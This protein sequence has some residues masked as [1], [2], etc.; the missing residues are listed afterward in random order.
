MKTLSCIL[1]FIIISGWSCNSSSG[2]GSVVV[3][4]KDDSLEYYPPT[5]AQLDR[6]VFR[7]Y[8]R[9]LSHYFDSTLLRRG[10]N[11]GIL[12]A[13]DGQVIYEKYAGF[14][15]MRSKDPFTDSTS[16][17]IA[18]SGKT[19]TGMGILRLVQENLLSLDDPMEKFFPEFPY[20]GVTVKMLLNHRSGLP[21]Y[22]YFMPK[23][24]GRTGM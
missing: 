18:S 2:S 1:I 24:N 21:N 12:V 17:H 14:S 22:V 3:P 9:E 5:P 11:G 15:D 20:D 10:F 13:K 23:K 8:F 6:Q 7:H 4:E 19:F 16:T